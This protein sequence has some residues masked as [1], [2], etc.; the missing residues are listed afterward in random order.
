MEL[1]GGLQA[2]LQWSQD[3]DS[4]AEEVRRYFARAADYLQILVRGPLAQTRIRGLH[5]VA[6]AALT[7]GGF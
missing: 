5:E 2:D 1:Q 4:W 7:C 3:V 6:H